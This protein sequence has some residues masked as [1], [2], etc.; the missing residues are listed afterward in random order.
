MMNSRWLS[1]RAWGV[2]AAAGHLALLGGCE[3]VTPYVVPPAE[4]GYRALAA[5]LPAPADTIPRHGDVVLTIAADGERYLADGDRHHNHVPISRAELAG[6]LRGLA[7][8]DRAALVRL[9]IDR[10]APYHHVI[11]VLDALA[12]HGLH[13][14]Q[15]RSQSGWADEYE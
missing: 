14:V 6:Y 13:H 10:L 5:E 9:Q 7:D 2:W 15:L 1:P 3:R 4:T 8:K 12:F 11:D